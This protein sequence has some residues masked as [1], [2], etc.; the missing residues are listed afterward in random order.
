[1]NEFSA[2]TDG[3]RGFG[4]VA[5]TL[6]TQV[7][8]AAVGAAAAGPALL[9]PAFGLIGGEFVT[10]F[11]AAQDR[12]TRSLTDLAVVLDSMSTTAATNADAY[13]RVDDGVATGLRVV[14]PGA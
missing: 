1:M 4:A 11:A 7:H 10:A 14:G 5:G 8:A 6:A 9:G 13:D 12:H 3:I 2:A